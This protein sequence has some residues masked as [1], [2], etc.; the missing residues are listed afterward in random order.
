MIGRFRE[1][2]SLIDEYV[3]FKIQ[4][5]D[6]MNI[7][8]VNI[9]EI[10]HSNEPSNCMTFDFYPE[11]SSESLNLTLTMRSNIENSI[12]FQLII[13]A[14]AIGPEVGVTS[15]VLILIFFNILLGSEVPNYIFEFSIF[16]LNQTICIFTNPVIVTT[17]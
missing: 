2:A 13:D 15:A 17:H 4:N 16:Y 11:T 5:R 1:T 9:Y 3:I 14:N 7:S 8:T 6:N 10:D 12:A